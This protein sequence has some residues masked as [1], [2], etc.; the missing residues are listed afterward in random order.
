MKSINIKLALIAS[1]VGA[2]L[3]ASACK[4]ETGVRKAALVIEKNMGHHECS[5]ALNFDCIKIA[6][7]NESNES[8]RIPTDLVLQAVVIHPAFVDVEFKSSEGNWTADTAELA[9][10]DAP[11][12][13]LSIAPGEKAEI[14]VLSSLPTHLGEASKSEFRVRLRDASGSTTVSPV[15]EEAR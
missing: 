1:L 11:R 6:I 2:A 14:Y 10:Y 7:L 12:Q 9:T 13:T 8:R 3:T 15:F 4:H 5:A